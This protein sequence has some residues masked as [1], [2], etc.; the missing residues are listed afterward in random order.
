MSAGPAGDP[1]RATCPGCGSVLPERAGDVHPCDWFR[2]LDHQVA[3][4]RGEI[5]RFEEELGAY[6]DSPRGRFEAW[7]AERERT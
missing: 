6:L 2:W 7:S 1:Q 3:L 4:R 5:D